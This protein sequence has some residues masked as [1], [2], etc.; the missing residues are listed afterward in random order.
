V[1]TKTI[2]FSFW[3]ALWCLISLLTAAGASEPSS[4]DVNRTFDTKKE[5]KINQISDRS[6]KDAFE[7]FKDVDFVTDV[8]YMHKAIYKTFR[9]RKAEGVDLALRTLSLPVTEHIH[10][11]TVHRARDLRVAKAILTVFPEDSI[12]RLLALYENGDPITKG[13]IIRVSGSLAG[14]DVGNFLMKALDEKTFCDPEDPE[15]DGPPMRICDLAYNQLVLR[16]RLK[17]VL[18]TIG[19]VHRIETRDSHI[20]I[21]KGKL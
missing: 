13:N 15:V 10:G 19:P 18:R 1:K 2:S 3:L 14:P 20:E 6:P 7:R 16:Y 8:D 4:P 17:N 21:L 12:P 9:Q 11:E 5:E